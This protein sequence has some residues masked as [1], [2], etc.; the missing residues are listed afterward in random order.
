MVSTSFT[1]CPFYLLWCDTNAPRRWSSLHKTNAANEELVS[2][3][4]DGRRVQRGARYTDCS[5]HSNSLSNKMGNSLL[6]V[7]GINHKYI[8]VERR[9]SL[10]QIER[11]TLSRKSCLN[12]RLNQISVPPPKLPSHP[13]FESRICLRG[14]SDRMN[15]E[16]HLF[17]APFAAG[18]DMAAVTWSN[19]MERLKRMGCGVNFKA[20]V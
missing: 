13:R 14:P 5:Y 10:R 18:G 15:P 11:R 8:V 1:H 9:S 17:D 7:R 4:V 12:F 16:N 20:D 19:L 6:A 2:R 3:L